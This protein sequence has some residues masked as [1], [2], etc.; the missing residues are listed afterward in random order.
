MKYWGAPLEIHGLNCHVAEN[1]ASLTITNDIKIRA[2][3]KVIILQS[4][5]LA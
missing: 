4:R 5:N 3:V 2:A 1:S